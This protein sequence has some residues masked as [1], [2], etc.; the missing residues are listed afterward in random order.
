MFCFVWTLAAAI[1][2]LILA[3][4]DEPKAAV[5]GVYILVIVLAVA[6]GVTMNVPHYTHL[7]R[8]S[9][10]LLLPPS[11]RDVNQSRKRNT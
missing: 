7:E 8:S 5:N 11:L 3:V 4:Q 9:V 1:N 10:S 6:V 2:G